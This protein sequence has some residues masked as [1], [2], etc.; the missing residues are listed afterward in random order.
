MNLRTWI[1]LFLLLL[2]ASACGDDGRTV[3]A[4]TDTSIALDG[5]IDSAP[6]DTGP[7]TA[8]STLFGPCFIDAQCPGPDAYCRTAAE[9]GVPGGQ[10]V[11][12]CAIT[13]GGAPDRTNCYEPDD[14]LYHVCWQFEGEE[15]ICEER[16]LN[17]A[18]CVREGFTCVGQGQF[19]SGDRGIC[20]PVCTNDE[21]CGAG[22]QCNR[23]SGRCVAEGTLPT[24]SENGDPCDNDSQC[25]SGTCLE[26][27]SGTTPTG[28]TDGYCLGVCILPIGYNSS[29][30]YT[31][32]GEGPG[33]PQGTCPDGDVCHPNGSLNRG[34]QGACVEACTS[35]ADCREAQ[36]Y[37]CRTSF[38]TASGTYTFPTGACF[39]IDCSSRACPTGYTCTTIPTASGPISV[40]ESM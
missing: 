29:S 19:S 17:G 1:G 21:E 14:D 2:G 36:G 26:E 37:F 40:C 23:Y 27:R 7:D 13:A 35:D 10:C 6:V 4:G 39:P 24:E 3:D 8:P 15:P 25:N 38:Q 18:D 20:V 11:R 34:D 16:C 32:A 30:F 31:D 33:L 28:W 9:D 12:R 5:S 22:A